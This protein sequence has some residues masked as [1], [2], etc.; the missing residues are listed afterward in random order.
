MRVK[1]STLV[2]WYLVFLI[3][4]NLSLTK[5]LYQVL[6]VFAST[7][8][9]VM[10]S[11]VSAVILALYCLCNKRVHWM[12]SPYIK[13]V[14]IICAALTFIIFV[15]II[16]T[17][18]TYNVSFRNFSYTFYTYMY[19]YLVYPIIFVFVTDKKAFNKMMKAILVCT[20]LGLLLRW[21]VSVVSNTTGVVL[22][23][24][25]PTECASENWIRNG[26]LRINS[27]CFIVSI[28]PIAMYV[29][30]TTKEISKKILCYFAIA[31]SIFYVVMVHQSRSFLI[32]LVWILFISYIVRQRKFTKK[33]GAILVTLIAF[34][35]LLN[36]QY[37]QNLIASFSSISE[38]SG[39][40][41]ARITSIEYYFGILKEHP[42]MG[43]G[44]LWNGY[45]GKL[46]YLRGSFGYAYLEDLGFLGGLFR[47]GLLGLALYILI[48]AR[49]INRV[50]FC[51]ENCTKRSG[52]LY[53][54]LC[55]LCFAYLIFGINIDWFYQLI[56]FSLPFVIAAFEYPQI[57]VDM[58]KNS[59]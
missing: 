35:L 57:V 34:C 53:L 49:M 46:R 38:L 55:S 9:I 21:G 45:E 43:L 30:T 5:I 3:A 36:T 50:R 7:Y 32:Y 4:M 15:Q 44:A 25:L 1:I 27:P 16:Y 8:H 13:Y 42:I 24:S 59:R 10:L 48:F 18:L 17:N 40:T 41:M 56:A 52:D 2:R 54:L 28:I 14:N 26:R 23:P 29:L 11:G 51:K 33:M 47:F 6:G 31:F 19:L 39:S 37:A 12:I 22:I 58:E 20:V